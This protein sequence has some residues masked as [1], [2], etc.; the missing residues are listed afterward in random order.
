MR[1]KKG[2]T[3]V[4]LLVT[5]VLLGIVAGIVIFNLTSVKSSSQKEEYERYVAAVKAAANVY[6]TEN[7]SV[8]DELYTDKAFIYIKVGTLIDNG[9]LSET[10]TNPYTNQHIGRDE[11]IKANLDSVTGVLTFEYP[12]EGKDTE[13]YLV[14]IGDIVEW[15]EPYDCYTGIGTYKLA[16]SDEDGNLIDLTATTQDKDGNTITNKEKYHFECSFPSGWSDYT[17]TT[18]TEGKTGTKYTNTSGH[19]EITYSWITDSGTKKSATRQLT[20][21]DKY[22][23]DVDVRVIKNDSYSTNGTPS[24]SDQEFSNATAYNSDVIYTP[25]YDC[26]TKEWS[27]LAFKVRTNGSTT[28]DLNYTV[29]KQNTS[30]RYVGQLGTDNNPIDYTGNDSNKIFIVDDGDV[31]YNVTNTISGRYFK[32]Y[33]YTATNNIELKQELV[34]PVCLIN[35]DSDFYDKSKEFTI[36]KPYSPVGVHDY[37]YE[38]EED[39]N[40]TPDYNKVPNITARTNLIPANN[41]KITT[42]KPD[43]TES[44]SNGGVCSFENKTY[45]VIYFRTINNNGYYGSWTTSP[46]TLKLTND[47]NNIIS[48]SSSNNTTGDACNTCQSVSTLDDTGKALVN[49]SSS[50]MNNLSCY[51]CNQAVYM[52]IPNDEGGYN[53]L[54]VLGQYDRGGNK[55]LLVTGD[56][57]GTASSSEIQDSNKTGKWVVQTCDGIYTA[58]FTY[59]EVVVSSLTFNLS[60]YQSK[61]IPNSLQ[62]KLFIQRNWYA[63][64]GSPDYSKMPSY[65]NAYEGWGGIWTDPNNINRES[66]TWEQVEAQIRKWQNAVVSS[67]TKYSGYIGAPTANEFKSI[68][69]NALVSP[70]DFW[71]GSSSVVNTGTVRV[72]HGDS[73]TI[74]S[75]F[76]DVAEANKVSVRSS[77]VGGQSQLK[78]LAELKNLYICS[79]SGT[80]SDPYVVSGDK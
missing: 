2:F 51:Y 71:L 72:S 56:S 18:V 22:L 45:D 15:G 33:K 10:L 55:T 60:K 69:K 58:Y 73:T 44:S 24:V 49:Q 75:S 62:D 8:F 42:Y 37:E 46:I 1:N 34:T 78:G 40:S 35:G 77:Y 16:L 28:D 30:N 43:I 25:Q 5:I 41:Q 32:N 80:Q 79:G 23:P 54:V 17:D 66:V 63:D 13:Q 27:F 21:S 3:L 39:K 70:Y 50:S 19:Y 38:W 9:Y 67:K 64:I 65:V 14:A 29:T 68:F 59:T 74:K 31:I 12:I 20:V 6:A 52:K 57:I 48:T 36:E 61:M 4:E 26:N 47:V 11:L 7:K 76:F 53:N